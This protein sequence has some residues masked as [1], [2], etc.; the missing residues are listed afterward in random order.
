MTTSIIVAIGADGSIGAGGDL[1][2]HIGADMKHF[3]ATTMGKPVIMGRKTFESLPGGALPGRRNIVVTRNAS[4][5]A[6]DVETV[7]SLEAALHLVKDVE[8]A[9][10]IGGAQIYEQALPLADR[11]YITRID[12][13]RTDADTFFPPIDEKEWTSQA[14]E[15]QTDPKSGLR[16]RFICLSRK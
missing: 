11:L 2:F 15:W 8:E 4:F 6:P 12:A 5:T 16:Y 9:M 13:Q 7:S 1:A 10:I 3:K 14:E